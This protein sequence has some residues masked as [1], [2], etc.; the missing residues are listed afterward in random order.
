MAVSAGR[1]AGV[2]GRDE[3]GELDFLLPPEIVAQL[4]FGKKLTVHLFWPL[5]TVLERSIDLKNQ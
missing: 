1:M 3:F 2:R 4:I 5:N